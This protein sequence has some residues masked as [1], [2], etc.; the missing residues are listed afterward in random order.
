MKP[1]PVWRHVISHGP[2]ELAMDYT[3]EEF[4]PQSFRYVYRPCEC[5]PVQRC[6]PLAP[7]GVTPRRTA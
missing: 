6:E 5:K 3:V 4:E 2:Y 7:A 1:E